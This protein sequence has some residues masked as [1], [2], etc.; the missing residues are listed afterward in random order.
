MM[1]KNKA[2]I[3]VFL[4]PALLS[5]LIMYLYPVTRTIIMSFFKV[6]NITTP[7]S[8]WTFAGI[9]N[10][11]NLWNSVIFRNS[12][13]NM[14]KI[15]L[16]GGVIVLSIAL[17]F[18]VILTSG[19][20]G[21]T[22]IRATI[23]LPNIISAIALATMWTQ[24]IFS[25][26][27]GLIKSVCEFFGWENAA[28]INWLS[29]EMK[30]T[31]MMIAFCF[32]SVGY[33]MLIF[34]SG[35]ERIPADLYEAATID[36]ANKVNMFFR[37]TIPLLKGIFK[38]NLTFWSINTIGFFVWSKMFSP[39]VSESATMTPLVYMFDIIFGTKGNETPRDSGAGAALGVTLTLFVLFVFLVMDKI[40]KDD[41][42][43][44]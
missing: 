4:T 11:Y 1:K 24:F 2:M 3:F 39:Q 7:V 5:F 29:T 25:Q 21:K 37:I 43:E 42:L 38:T 40:I 44:F 8:N 13:M 12:I 20:R 23:Y 41:D 28:T 22:F 15:W 33:Y 6:E 9:N 35:I 16:F 32:G 10:F 17:L 18:A 26:K 30:F 31:S 36:G 27:Y 19:V 34:L 14:L